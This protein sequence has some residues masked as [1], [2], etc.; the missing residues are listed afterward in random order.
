ML[1]R[2]FL[3]DFRPFVVGLLLDPGAEKSLHRLKNVTRAGRGTIV[4][5]GEDCSESIEIVVRHSPPFP[6]KRRIPLLAG[7]LP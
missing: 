6:D 3:L 7:S 2:V 4:R 1:G 5:I